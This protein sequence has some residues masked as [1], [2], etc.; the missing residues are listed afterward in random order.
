MFWLE[1]E[2][3]ATGDLAMAELP[4]FWLFNSRI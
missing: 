3:G 2:I 1:V 4:A